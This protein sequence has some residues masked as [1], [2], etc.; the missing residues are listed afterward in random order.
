[1]FFEI[2][3]LFFLFF[4]SLKLAHPAVM[5]RTGCDSPTPHHWR[6]TQESTQIKKKVYGLSLLM[7]LLKETNNLSHGGADA[8]IRKDAR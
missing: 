2:N 1:M 3:D 6:A 8:N 5:P 4:L 7:P